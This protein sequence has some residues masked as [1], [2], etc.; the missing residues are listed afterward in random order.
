MLKHVDKR[1]SCGCHCCAQSSMKSV[2][3]SSM[4]QHGDGDGGRHRCVLLAVVP[5]K[6]RTYCP[7]FCLDRSV[8]RDWSKTE[9]HGPAICSSARG[10]SCASKN[11]SSHD[12]SC[13]AAMLD[14]C[15]VLCS[16]AGGSVQD[17]LCHRSFSALA[18]HG[19][20]SPTLKLTSWRGGASAREST[21]D[22]SSL[23][24]TR[25][26]DEEGTSRQAVQD[27]EIRAGQS[28]VLQCSPTCPS[29]RS[30]AGWRRVAVWPPC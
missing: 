12:W 20:S 29:H 13:D 6:T 7:S 5:G 30:K 25:H 24:E 8:W 14:F 17:P 19:S 9:L 18:Y 1:D 23:K 10:R 28:Q 4:S 15:S 11:V 22:V 16:L 21:R 3:S 27:E 2:A 26:Q